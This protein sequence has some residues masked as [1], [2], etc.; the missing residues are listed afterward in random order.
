M[1]KAIKNYNN[2][3]LEPYLSDETQIYHFEKHHTGYANTLTNLTNGTDLENLSINE[4]ISKKKDISPKIFNN[5]A[6]IFNHDFYWNSLSIKKTEPSFNLLSEIN[7]HFTNI[8]KFYET[9]IN[10]ASEM[11]GSGWSWLVLDKSSNDNK[12]FIMNTSNA[13]TPIVYDNLYPLLTIDLWEHS[14]YIDYRNDRKSY[15]E[16]LVK[17]CLNWDF[18]N[19]QFEK[20]TVY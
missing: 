17:N 1:F 7:K 18:A 5:A 6:Q 8:D 11:F 12:L 14:Y 16:T 4:I 3:A 13:D 10:T 15:I 19:E 2:K 9:Y 20:N